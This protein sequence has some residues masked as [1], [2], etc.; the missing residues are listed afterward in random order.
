MASTHSLQEPTTQE[1]E[2]AYH[3]E[4][5]DSD[6]SKHTFGELVKGKKVAVIFIRHFC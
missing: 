6:G 4:L 1:L 2:E 5:L 3:V